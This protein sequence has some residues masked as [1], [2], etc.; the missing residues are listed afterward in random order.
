M[1]NCWLTYLLGGFALAMVAC[2]P[3]TTSTST[4]T[5]RYGFKKIDTYV[6]YLE[7]RRE[8][9]AEITFRTDSTQQLEKPVSVNGELLRPT[10]RPK[11]GLQYS[12]TQT[13]INFDREQ[14]FS[15]TEKD[16]S[17]QKIEITLPAFDSAVILSQKI[18]SHEK[19]G[20]LGWK[21]ASFDKEDVMVLLFTDAEGQVF[22]VNHNGQTSGT[23]YQILPE[24]AQRLALGPAQLDITRKRVQ[25]HKTNGQTQWST[26]EY[27]YRPILF[28][29]KP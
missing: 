7:A 15:Y 18:L 13:A 26:I 12:G 4:P 5:D 16:G 8:W 2:H 9:Y 28:E 27:Y 23:Q 3:P 20:L 22:S 19:G 1:K 24:I 10:R 14:I 17:Q 6:R 21:G 25:I 11:I 29:V